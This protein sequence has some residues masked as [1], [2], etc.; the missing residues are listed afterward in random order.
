MDAA[1]SQK[2]Q[3]YSHPRGRGG[4]GRSVEQAQAAGEEAM[5]DAVGPRDQAPILTVDPY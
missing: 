4:G 1:I 2:R 5:G 3:L